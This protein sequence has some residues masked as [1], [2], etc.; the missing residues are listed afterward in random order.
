MRVICG[1]SV[2][3]MYLIDPTVHLS[4]FSFGVVLSELQFIGVILA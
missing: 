4:S 3:P 1:Y 2:N